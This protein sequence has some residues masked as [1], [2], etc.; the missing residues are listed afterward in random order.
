[1]DGDVSE[2]MKKR[3]R[4]PLTAACAFAAACGAIS[5][6]D[7]RAMPEGVAGGAI[8]AFHGEILYAGGTS[9]RDG[10]KHWLAE[11][12]RYSIAAD[13]WEAGPALP[14]VLAYGA[15]V[16]SG[17][18]LEI[19]GGMNEKGV[20]RKCWRL[21]RGAS[22]WRSSGALPVDSVLSSAQMV[23]G[24]VYLFGG[25]PDVADLSQCSAAV[26]R[27]NRKGTWAEVSK[28]PEVP[29]ALSATAVVGDRIY[30]FGGCTPTGPG[31][32]RNLDGAHEFQTASGHWRMLRS[33]PSAAR[34][35]SAVALDDHRILVAGGYAASQ[36]DAKSEGPDFGFSAAAW[37]YHIDNDQFESVA[38]LPFPVAGME[39]VAI[40]GKMFG[41][42]GEHRMRG[43]TPRLIEA[44][45]GNSSR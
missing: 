1:M 8:A 13:S 15:Y 17:D 42:G 31:T 40:D 36:D 20:S 26:W 43:R 16:R 22:E 39:L 35:M 27:R 24:I 32:I 34:A 18:V 23:A 21:D 38:P 37:V 28:I 4:V 25:C 44:S 2:T 9:W 41:A 33:L 29:V 11:T 30:L 10:V 7:R 12:R 3:S 14:E 6:R 5:W 45:L 19:L